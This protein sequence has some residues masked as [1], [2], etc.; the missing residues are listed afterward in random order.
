MAWLGDAGDL[1]CSSSL[2]LVVSPRSALL[3]GAVPRGAP[4][5]RRASEPASRCPP[6]LPVAH[7]GRA[8]GRWHASRRW[9]R[10]GRPVPQPFLALPGRSFWVFYSS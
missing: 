1:S 10:P 3:V 9:P 8:L 4:Q 7:G 6:R 5:S 2:V